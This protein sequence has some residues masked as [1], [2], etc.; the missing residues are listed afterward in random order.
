LPSKSKIPPQLGDPL[1]QV[2]ERGADLVDAFCFHSGAAKRADYTG[3]GST[4][5]VWVTSASSLPPSELMR[6]CHTIV[7]LPR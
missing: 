3:A 4:I 1:A 7:V 6:V 2:V 5:C